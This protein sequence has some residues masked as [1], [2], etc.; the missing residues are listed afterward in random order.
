MQKRCILF[1]I[2]SLSTYKNNINIY[3]HENKLNT[4][5]LKN[6]KPKRLN[7]KA[8]I[9]RPKCGQTD[10]TPLQTASMK[11]IDTN[12]LNEGKLKW[13]AISR[14]LHARYGGKYRFGDK[15]KLYNCGKF[16]NKTYIIQDLMHHKWKNKIDILIPNHDTINYYFKNIKI[17]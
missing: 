2:M 13:V 1:L 8:S 12:L 4:L 11:I 16:S 17:K 7:Y 5:L 14:D 9:Y 6:I 15:I 10:S 3:C